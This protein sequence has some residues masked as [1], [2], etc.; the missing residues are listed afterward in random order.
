MARRKK[1]PQYGL[2]KNAALL[3]SGIA[4]GLVLYMLIFPNNAMAPHASSN[5]LNEIN[6]R[7]STGDYRMDQYYAFK[8]MAPKSY[9]ASTDQMLGS[10]LLVGGMAPPRLLLS[11]NQ[12]VFVNDEGDFLSKVWEYNPNDC[13]SIWTTGGLETIEDWLDLPGL[14][15]GKLN[16]REEIQVGSRKAEVYRLSRSDG[17]VYAGFMPIESEHGISYFF[18]TCNEN[19]KEDFINVIKSLKLRSEGSM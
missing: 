7:F 9:V 1:K 19:N 12:Q 15:I 13:I 14:E 2:V 5:E 4:I 17:N 11:K 18:R 16:N 8:V 3:L 10:Y 6:N